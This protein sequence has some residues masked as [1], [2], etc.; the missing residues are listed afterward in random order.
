[1]NKRG[2]IAAFSI[3]GMVV[4]AFIGYLL[5]L[6]LGKYVIDEKKFVMNSAATLVDERG[7]EITRLYV[8]NRDIVS[9]KEIP[10]HVQQAFVAVEDARFYDHH[11]I[12]IKAIG[13]A[14]YKDLLAGSKVEGGS[15]ITQQLAKNVFLSSDK[16]WLRKTKEVVIALNLEKRYS[17]QKILE[18]YL[19]QIYFGHG[20]Y[21]IQAASKFYFNKGVEQLTIE[22]GALLAAL[23]K[24]PGAYSPILHPER[25]L[26]RRNVVLDLM[27]KS[28]Y[29]TS[30][31]TV[32]LQGRTLALNVHQQVK[33]PAFLTY[34]DMVMDEAKEKFAI[35]NEEL[36]RGG[37]KITVPM[38]PDVQKTAYELF[39]KES[40]F[41]GTDES[42]QGSFVLMDQKTGGV[43]SVIGGREYVQKGL[44]RVKM[45]R[46][47]GS[48]IKP[49][50]VYGP[51]LQEKKFE[52]YSLLKD[53]A[54]T[55][56]GY[57]PRNID[58]QYK[59]TMTMYDAL[60]HSTNAPAVW[61]LNELGIGV[62]KQYLSRLG[63]E[64]EDDGLAIA[65]GGLKEGVSPLSLVSAYRAFSAEGKT[66]EPFFIQKI[67]DRHGTVIAEAESKEKKVFSK[68]TAW[69]MTKMLEAVV[70]E[71]TA[72]YGNFQGALAGKTGTTSY[73]GV[74]G[75]SKDTWFV[76]YTNDVV[77]TVWMGYD[78]TDKQHYLTKGSSY[79]TRL[80]KDIL[81]KSSLK[82]ASA[83]TPPENVKDL[84]EPIHLQA[85]NDLTSNVIF[86][87]LGL[88][89]VRLTWTPSDD[90]RLVYHI[91]E[92]K[93]GESRLVGKVRGKG[94]YDVE[95]VNVL[96]IPSFYIVP[97]NQLTKQ[98]GDKSNEVIPAFFSEEAAQ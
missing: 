96:N 79:P 42:V 49:L 35:S 1:M 7:N 98:Q 86:K 12:D 70:K 92:L 69:Y 34:L 85:V 30:E 68:Q 80:F 51:A 55:Y 5:I 19:N 6:F 23:P 75:A 17:K 89:T 2:M 59:G 81:T 41:P 95:R 46:Q 16:T 36:L 38:N 77:G 56:G 11:G 10:E 8:E 22:Q 44:N 61:A 25:S 40:Y 32:R 62:S 60:V 31:Q 64:I 90:K 28:N 24:A 9:I 87:P 73:T 71:G 26:E 94:Q 20:A 78:T 66:I 47:P 37:Y 67:E 48:T 91:Y 18:M 65:L 72:K 57:T 63:L 76:G 50:A 27:R 14:L 4:L 45:K 15:T 97:Y 82:H 93:G 84:P 29:L 3:I 83:F 74:Q 43:L 53:Q 52:P 21:G 58:D 39:N 13:R 33:E 54:L 88:F